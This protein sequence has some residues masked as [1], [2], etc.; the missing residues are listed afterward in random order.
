MDSGATCDVKT[1]KEKEKL[2]SH[3]KLRLSKGKLLG[4]FN[5]NCTIPGRKHKPL[6]EVV[7]KGQHP[8]L[9]GETREHLGF[10]HFTILDSVLKIEHSQPSPPTKEKLIKKNVPAKVHFDLDPNVPAVQCAPRNVPIA[11]KAAVNAQLDKYETEGHIA[12][13][14]E[15]SD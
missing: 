13:V 11:M 2:A 5:N 8:L 4:I 9:S 1:L 15:P 14:T 6:F 12:P 10:M 7:E 3:A